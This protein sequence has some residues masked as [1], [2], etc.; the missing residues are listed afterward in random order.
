[1]KKTFENL[2]DAK[3]QRIISACIEEFSENG[4]EKS[5]TDNIVGKAGISKGGLYEYTESKKDLYIYIVTHTYEKLY[6][7][8][9]QK[10]ERMESQLPSDILDRFRI[11]SEFAID[12]Y[13]DYPE[14]V[15]MIVKTYKIHDVEIEKEV[16]DI[17]NSQFMTIFGNIDG[18]SLRYDKGRIFDLL[19]WLLLK[20]RYD[21]LVEL[22]HVNDLDALKQDYITNWA[23]FLGV[24]KNGIYR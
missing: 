3:K 8:L 21:F 19:M 10:A 23:F 12:F 11:V 7:Y 6:N 20:T 17:F 24:L 13:I 15:K 5:T 18:S 9:R 4:Y 16:R 2:P 22:D 14:Y 1:M